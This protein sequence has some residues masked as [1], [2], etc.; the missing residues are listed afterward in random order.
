V[1][2]RVGEGVRVRVGPKDGNGRG[3]E[4][5]AAGRGVAV[6]AAQ[7]TQM[8][9]INTSNSQRIRSFHLIALDELQKEFV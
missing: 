8:I 3:V 4:V 6:G 5:G 1:A 7:A 2:R 9:T